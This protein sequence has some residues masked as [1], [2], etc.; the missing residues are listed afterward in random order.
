ML[1]TK[2]TTT[3]LSTISAL[4]LNDGSNMG[5]NVKFVSNWQMLFLRICCTYLIQLRW[6]FVTVL[7]KTCLLLFIL[8]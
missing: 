2:S 5:T 3:P 4:K 8:V 6:N 7:W 1:G